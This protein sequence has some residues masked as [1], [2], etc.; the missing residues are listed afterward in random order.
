MMKVVEIRQPF[1]YT[2]EWKITLQKTKRDV[3]TCIIERYI[4]EGHSA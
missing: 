1:F 4:I 2:Q 3:Y